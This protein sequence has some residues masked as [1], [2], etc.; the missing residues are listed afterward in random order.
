MAGSALEVDESLRNEGQ[1]P[2]L[3]E[4]MKKVEDLANVDQEQ[5]DEKKEEK[6]PT[7]DVPPHILQMMTNLVSSLVCGL[8]PGVSFLF[9]CV[10]LSSA[11]TSGASG[12]SG[13][14]SSNV[15]PPPPRRRPTT[16]PTLAARE[17]T[18]YTSRL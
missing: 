18:G 4:L 5:K 9:T 14:S 17:V 1:T 2:K 3:D 11:R 7:T 16:A 6:A 8:R 13:N 12:N 10:R 15:S